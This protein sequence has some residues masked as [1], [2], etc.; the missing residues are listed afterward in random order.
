MSLTDKYI[1]ETYSK[2]LEGLNASSKKE[3]IENLTRSL[4]RESASIEEKFYQSFGAFASDKSAEDIV[5]EI[6]RSRKFR[7][8]EI[9]F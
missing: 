5:K 2:M 7:R 9:Q 1:V 8:K 3:I 4:K 6:K